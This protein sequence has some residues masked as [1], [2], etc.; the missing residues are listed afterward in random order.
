MGKRISIA[1]DGPAGAGK[2]T[3][4]K[5]VAAKKGY[6]YLDTGAMYRALTYKAIRDQI[7][8]E[9]EDALFAALMQSSISFKMGE[10]CQEV[11]LDSENVTD[12][13]RSREINLGV[14]TIAAHAKVRE[15]MVR[16]QQEY[17]KNG[18]VVMDGRDIGTHVMP[19]AEVKIYLIASVS[20][21][22]KRR[23]E[24]NIQKGFASNLEELEREISARDLYD[25]TRDVAPLTKAE[26]AIELDTTSMSLD[27][28][29]EAIVKIIDERS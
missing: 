26:D 15:E 25:S 27:S 23:H 11:F 3:V 22:A 1:I 5:I 17:G 9:D 4:A 14:S 7:N 16:L 19:N 10:N 6:I 13:I 28:V 20:E 2:S 21:R 24:E 29:V 12:K 18:G 8:V